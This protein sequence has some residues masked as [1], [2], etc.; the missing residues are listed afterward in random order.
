[1]RR[2]LGLFALALVL[3]APAA[4]ATSE[5]QQLLLLPGAENPAPTLR[6]LAESGERMELEFTLPALQ[7]ED[8]A[9]E[10]QSFQAL[11][12]QGGGLAGEEGQAGLPT[13]SRLVAVPAGMAVSARVVASEEAAFQGY[14]P[15]PVQ[16]A[17]AKSP[18]LDR[19]WYAGGEVARRPLVEVGEPAIMHGQRMVAVSLNP[20]HWSPASGSLTVASRV[21]LE[22]EFS[23]SD[24]RATPRERD[25]ISASFD[26]LF[27]DT[28]L[29]YRAGDAQVGPGTCLFIVVN[30]ANMINAINPLVTWRRQQGYNVV[31]ETN[32]TSSTTI[33]KNSILT[34]YNN[35]DPPLEFVTIVGDATGTYGV[36]TFHETYSGYNG[37]GDNEY[38]L[39]EGGDWLPD[40]HVGRLSCDDP[41]NLTAIVTKILGY[42]QNPPTA[43]AGWFTRGVCVGDASSSGITCVWA[44]QWLA[45]Q[46][47]AKGYTSVTEI[48]SGNFST[49]MI[50]AINAGSSVFGY[51]GYWN[52]SGLTE[53]GILSTANNGKLPYAVIPT[54]DTG[55]FEA[56]GTCRSEAF[57]K[58]TNG[59][60]IGAVGT[61]TIGT[62][63]RYNNCYYMGNWE[64]MINGSD[65]HIGSGHTRG[66]VE[67]YSNFINYENNPIYIWSVWNNLMGD[68]AT[69]MWTGYPGTLAVTY[70][71]TVPVGANSIAVHV[72]SGGNALAGALVSLY[73][74]GE[75]RSVGYTDAGGD[76]NL[77]VAGVTAGTVNVT[78]SK[79]NYFPHRGTLTLGSIGTYLAFNG[80]T[81]DDDTSGS[82]LGNG[83]HQVNPGESLELPVALRNFGTT[84]ASNV[85]A[86]LSTSSPYVNVLDG[87]ETFGNIN[88]GATVWSAEDFDVSIAAGAPDGATLDLDLLAT[89]GAASWTSLLRLTVMSAAFTYQSFTW[90]GGGGTLSPGET[91][92]FTV[93]LQNTGSVAA[94]SVTATLAS[95]SPWITITDAAGSY[96]TVVIGGSAVN[97]GNPF[98]FNVS[99]DCFKGH[100]ATFT[101]TLVFDGGRQDVVEFSLPVGTGTTI[102]PIGPDLYGYYAF[103]NTDT[104]YPWAPTYAWVE[105]SAVGTDI[106]L[107]DLGWEQDDTNLVNLPF[108][109]SYYG[110]DFT[111]VSICS[112]GWIAMGATDM[113]TY[114]NWTIPA[115]GNP[116]AMIAGFFDNLYLNASNRVYTWYDSDNGRFVIQYNN[117]R[118]DYSDA[119]EKFEIILYDPSVWVTTTGDGPILMQYMAVGNTDVRDGYAT[120][121][122]TN[123]DGTDGLL[124]TYA[125]DYAP[126][127]AVLQAGR[128]I[129][130]QPIGNLA[131]GTLQGALTNS[132]NGG[133]PVGN[134]PVHLLENNQSLL[135]ATDG[136]YAGSVQEGVYTA[137]VDH[138]SFTTVTVNGVNIVEDQ[139]T[140]LNFQLTDILGPYITNV[141]VH[142]HTEDTVGPYLVDANIADFSAIS[143]RHCYYKINGGGQFEAPLTLIDVGSGLYRAEIPGLP[144]STQISYWFEAEDAA[145]NASRNPVTPGTYYDF[146][147]VES[148]TVAAHS[149]ETDNGWTVGQAGDAATSGVWTRVDPIGVF[150]GD[151]PVQPDNDVSDPGTLCYVTGNAETGSQGADDVD[152][153][154]TTLLTP[155]FDLSEMLS[156]TVS[157]WYWYVNDTGS[158]PDEDHW[159]VE[160]TDDGVNWV[161]VQYSNVSTHAWAQHSFNVMDYVDLTSTVRLRFLASDF[162][163]GSIVEA[164]IDEFNLSGYLTPDPTAVDEGAV[165]TSV[166][167]LQ[168]VPN[169]FNPKT[170]IR[171]GLPAAAAADLKVYDTTGRLVRTLLDGAP[172]GAGFHRV[173][174]DGT[175]DRGQRASTGVYFYVLETGAERQH[176]KMLLLK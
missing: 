79:H 47:W 82:S 76:V 85:S 38:S 78:V 68:P 35:D 64:G 16:P 29:G 148:H 62:H 56:V 119:I 77:P 26:A 167:L 49:S 7:Y 2:L 30:D 59:G 73:K 87:V 91:G 23:G 145:S 98:A 162:G 3:L 70:P 101:L 19:A 43:D 54:C 158:N 67:L 168:N 1:M 63:T 31:V 111:Q 152:G 136:H 36:D 127:A 164:G 22:L 153:G 124:Y 113:V 92:T 88:A 131:L 6:L 72:T 55:S 57:L 90:S 94:G 83:D 150:A 28:L 174:W 105:I 169:P 106:G 102:D 42:E 156:A 81:I 176:G 86:T 108:T 112:N 11:A 114:R 159:T 139:V 140:N 137:R 24:D 110:E 14:R 172:Y 15:L 4:Q 93:S 66:K 39:L 71:A 65:H 146:Y 121:G 171:F 130:F 51:R 17:D 165:P 96:G 46:L 48:Y 154:Q 116:N 166:T 95:A 21:E 117:L 175:D 115:A 163:G 25:S 89:A 80:V 12:I 138:E 44:S 40:V 60:G 58:D 142:E 5:P 104:N 32:G 141:T 161:Q 9:I 10:G 135:S 27:R 33:I 37:E 18:V 50:A 52:M 157:Y 120:V 122:I 123:L 74:S 155:W 97:T 118:N 107:T 134:V 147:I 149:F 45:D 75:L 133:T 41:T 100:L 160:I 84:A 170:E 129:L 125:A 126:T 53:S 132:S 34:H 99:S 69:E 173:S 144:Q 128:A 8:V 103:D 143:E 61:A 13:Y 20:V 109:F 151:E